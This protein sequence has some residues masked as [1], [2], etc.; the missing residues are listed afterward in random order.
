MLAAKLKG[1]EEDV[2][3][4]FPGEEGK[5]LDRRAGDEVGDAWCSDGVAGSHEVWG[6]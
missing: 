4:G 5:P 3:V 1:V 2:E 6:L